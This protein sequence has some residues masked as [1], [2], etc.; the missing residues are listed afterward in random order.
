[1][2]GRAVRDRDV[3]DEAGAIAD[4]LSRAGFGPTVARLVAFPRDQPARRRPRRRRR[5]RR[6]GRRA[7]AARR[8]GA[9]GW[10]GALGVAPEARRRGLGAALTEAA[11]ARLRER[12]ADDRA[13]LRHRHGP[14]ALRAPRLRDRGRGDRLA[15]D[16]R[17][18]PAGVH[19]ARACARTTARRSRALDRA[20]TGEDRADRARRAAPARGR[21]RRARGRA[22]RLG[23]QGALR[24]GHRDL[25]RRRRGGRRADGRRG[26]RP[27]AGDARRARRQR[28]RRRR[29]CAAGASAPPTPASA[30]ASGRRS[31]GGPSASS[32]CSTSSGARERPGHPC[33]SRYSPTS[34]AGPGHLRV[35]RRSREFPGGMAIHEHPGI[36]FAPGEPDS[37]CAVAAV[38]QEAARSTPGRPARAGSRA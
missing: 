17:R 35:P 20:A 9:T 6:A 12:G 31:P 13:A 27:G 1:M 28:R 37:S 4:L 26:E 7:C 30:C 23:G 15:R 11:I 14:A 5:R 29:A 25:R 32:G 2:V 33:P 18:V 10:I 16:R 38:L 8:F 19:G 24:R 36:R 3:D 22:R 34:G 21:R